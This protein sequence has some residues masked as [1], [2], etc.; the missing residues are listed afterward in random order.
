MIFINYKTYEQGTG[1]DAV[2]LTRMVERVADAVHIKII[3]VVQSS[4]IKEVVSITKLEVWTQKIDP[5]DFGAHTGAVL[6]EAV[7]EDGAVGTFLNHSEA[8]LGSFEALKNSVKRADEVGL[9]TLVF[10]G[11]IEELKKILRL[12]P[13]FASYEPPE[14]VGSETTS[15]AKAKPEIISKA[16]K[17]AKNKGIPLVVGAGIKSAQDVRKSIELGCTGVAVASDVVSSTDPEKELL[18]LVRGLN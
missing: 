17:L 5:F 7:Y 2:E 9:K 8:K 3:P 18:D 12:K 14:L 11:N 4:D 6:P 13:T 16:V 10:A 15:V 1:A